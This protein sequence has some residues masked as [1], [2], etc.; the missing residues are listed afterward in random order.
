MSSHLAAPEERPGKTRIFLFSEPTCKE[1]G[2]CPGRSLPRA[3]PSAQLPRCGLDIRGI[4]FRI[5]ATEIDVS[6]IQGW[7]IQAPG[8]KG[9]SESLTGSKEGT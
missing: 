5:L 1:D 9:I 3:V 7:G 2:A 8:L 4:A 6:L